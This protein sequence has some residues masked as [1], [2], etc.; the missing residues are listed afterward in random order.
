MDLFIDEQDITHT[1][2]PSLSQF[3]IN[4]FDFFL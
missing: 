2:E 1:S 4:D 3:D